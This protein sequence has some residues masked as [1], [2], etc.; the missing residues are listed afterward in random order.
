MST[1][2]YNKKKRHTENVCYGR[3]DLLQVA[4]QM[5]ADFGNDS[6][7]E[8]LCGVLADAAYNYLIEIRITDQN[9]LK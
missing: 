6:V 2:D 8:E 9:K 3:E 7:G 4:E 5:A 1:V